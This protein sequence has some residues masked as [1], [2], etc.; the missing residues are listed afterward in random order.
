MFENN[1]YH[2]D[3]DSYQDI[4]KITYQ[5]DHE[6]NINDAKEL[7]KERDGLSLPCWAADCGEGES[8]SFY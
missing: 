2:I 5:D 7:L 3:C 6:F 4:I 8:S 1:P